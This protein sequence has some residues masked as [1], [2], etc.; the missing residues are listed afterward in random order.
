[1]AGR[2]ITF[3]G[4]EGAG[5]TTQMRRLAEFLGERGIEVVTTRE[6]GGTPRAEAVREALLAGK[7]QSL[8]PEAEAL[9]F[10]AARVDHID[11]LIRPS[12][13]SG[14]WVLCDRFIDSTRA[15]Q[16]AADGVDMELIG[17]LERV[18]VGHTKPNLTLILDVPVEI[19]LKRAAERRAGEPSKGKG[20]GKGKAKAKAPPEADRFEATDAELHERRRKA[21]LDIARQEPLR[22]VVVQADRS[23][24]DIARDIREVVEQR[25]L[26]SVG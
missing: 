23:E 21:F 20:R 12:L 15:Y 14:K 25:L 10:A 26:A 3:E 13:K 5:K 9:A 17:F 2:F 4:G 7:L 8:G 22:C 18:A 24:D 6:P 1:M 19:G 11:K 16:G